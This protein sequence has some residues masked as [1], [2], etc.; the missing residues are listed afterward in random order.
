M[1]DPSRSHGSAARYHLPTVAALTA[2]LCSLFYFRTRYLADDGAFYLRY[3]DNICRGAFWK[4][5][6]GEPPV[7]GASAPLW[8]LVLAIPMSLGFKEAVSVALLGA[9]LTLAAIGLTIHSLALLLGRDCALFLLPFVALNANLMFFATSGLET[10]LTYLLI[11]L[12]VYA[13]VGGGHW[14]FVGIV[15]G[16]M[17]VQKLDLV[18]IAALL[19]FAHAIAVRR[20]ERRMV[21]LA[22][23]MA[24]MW[25]AFAW[26]YFGSPVPNSFLT[27]AFHQEGVGVSPLPRFWFARQLFLHG[28]Q[29]YAIAFAA[30]GVVSTRRRTLPLVVFL[31]G[32]IAVHV[33]AYTIHPPAESYS[34]YVAPSLFSL[35]LIGALGAAAYFQRLERSRLLR[36]VMMA[37]PGVAVLLGG[38]DEHAVWRRSRQWTV[39]VEGAREAAGRYVAA[40]T[41][42][43]A[44][45]LTGFGNTAYWSKRYVYD[46]SFLNR[47][48][49]AGDLVAKY[50]P[51]VVI[52]ASYETGIAPTHYNP[53]SGYVV[54][55]TF[56]DA[57]RGGIDFYVVV[58]RRSDRTTAS[59]L[60][61][62]AAHPIS[63]VKE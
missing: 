10:P 1:R 6:P 53:R 29:K 16:L 63:R 50:R 58:L 8:P 12:A 17:F 40:S 60:A 31:G 14:A 32:L 2:C 27:K 42:A 41:P 59:P 22:L 23:S 62:G 26:A 25:Y 57:I 4:W 7:W 52:D 20:I 9:I 51:D 47:P 21:L 3:A 38:I 61:I 39:A 11:A 19:L 36:I 45:V 30:I 54:D 5:N 43:D 28:I 33:A 34:W 35:S 44:K 46:A 18:P 37:V 15:A 13:I 55:R 56:D 49:E 48:Y 24:A